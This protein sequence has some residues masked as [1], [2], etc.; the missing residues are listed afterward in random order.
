MLDT[1]SPMLF[2]SPMYYPKIK[3]E[4]KNNLTRPK[5]RVLDENS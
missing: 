5:S 1:V 4:F 3:E 2:L